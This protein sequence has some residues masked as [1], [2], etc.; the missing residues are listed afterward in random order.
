MVV[1]TGDELKNSLLIG[2]ILNSNEYCY[3]SKKMEKNMLQHL[4]HTYFKWTGT[5]YIP[6]IL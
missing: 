2:K 5:D 6:N 4:I 3:E 1:I